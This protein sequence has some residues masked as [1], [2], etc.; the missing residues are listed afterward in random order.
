ME[1]VFKN[2]IYDPYAQDPS[3]NNWRREEHIKLETKFDIWK[4]SYR[5]KYQSK[6][7]K[8]VKIDKEF[9]VLD[10][11]DE[12]YAMLQDGTLVD[13]SKY[14][15]GETA[16]EEDRDKIIQALDDADYYLQELNRKTS[17]LSD[18]GKMFIK[19]YVPKFK[20]KDRKRLSRL[21]N[22][23]VTFNKIIFLANKSPHNI[24]MDYYLSKILVKYKLNRDVV[25]ILNY[26]NFVLNK[27]I[28]I[29]M[30]DSNYKLE[31]NLKNKLNLLRYLLQM[32]VVEE[33]LNLFFFFF[34]LRLFVILAIDALFIELDFLKFI[35]K[36]FDISKI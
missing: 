32:L 35:Q 5:S 16:D 10:D 24:S 6:L 7:F 17:I 25:V 8:G 12:G 34:S 31:F 21:L 15:I 13:L 19:E 28:L 18:N 2:V 29:M 36:K 1:D 9:I 30:S 27:Y 33:L 11:E 4:N 23:M 20:L 3:A 26:F 14:H 22:L